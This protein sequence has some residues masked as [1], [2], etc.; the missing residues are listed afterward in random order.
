MSTLSE[1]KLFIFDMDGTIYL[2]EQVFDSAVA[3]I[4]R[5]RREGKRVLFF[6][7]NASKK[8]ST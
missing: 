2:G 5:L 8:P 4:K 6:K 1:K 7:N 3:L